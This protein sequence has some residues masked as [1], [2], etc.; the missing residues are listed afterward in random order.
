QFELH[1]AVVQRLSLQT[2]GLVR[3]NDSNTWNGLKMLD[4]ERGHRKAEA[5]RSSGEQAIMETDSMGRKVLCEPIDSAARITGEYR[6]DTKPGQDS[7]N[8][9]QLRASFR[10][11]DQLSCRN[12]RA[13]QATSSAQI[14]EVIAGRF[15]SPKKIN[16]YCRL[17]ENSTRSR[18]CHTR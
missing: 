4:I 6:L 2:A 13:R 17:D 8:G 15:Q 10:T 9:P 12:D 7:I 16:Q 14:I 5:K 18:R 11:D 3:A 1:N